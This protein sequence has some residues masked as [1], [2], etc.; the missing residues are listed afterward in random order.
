MSNK[1]AIDAAIVKARKLGVPEDSLRQA[2]VLI[3]E[4]RINVTRLGLDP[5]AVRI[6]LLF[7][8]L[9]DYHFA[10]TKLSV[11]DLATLREIANDLYLGTRW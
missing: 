8:D 7:G 9:C 1:A 2:L 11:K 10:K 5:R 4:F 6:A 3:R